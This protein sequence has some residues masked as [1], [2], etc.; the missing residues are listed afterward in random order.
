MSN[1][2]MRTRVSEELY[3]EGYWLDGKGNQVDLI[4]PEG[5]VFEIFFLGED[6]L[7]MCERTHWWCNIIYEIFITDDRIPTICCT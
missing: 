5:K 3:N 1:M 2:S 7:V 6:I 4:G